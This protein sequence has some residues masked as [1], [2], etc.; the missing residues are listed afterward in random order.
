MHTPE[1]PELPNSD[2]PLDPQ[3]IA[4]ESPQDAPQVDP[5][6]AVLAELIYDRTASNKVAGHRWLRL[7]KPEELTDEKLAALLIA[8]RQAAQPPVLGTIAFIEGSKDTY[9]YDANIMTGQFAR[10]DALIEDK[11]ILRTIAEVTR[12]D[13]QLYP[14][15]TEFSKMMGYPFRFSLDEVEGAAARMQLHDEYQDI[16]VVQASNGAKA[17]YSSQHIKEGY[18][19]SLLEASEVEAREWP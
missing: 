1:H 9:Y 15:P 2:Q 8:I 12:S 18:A 4:E 16:G 13:C 14:R 10:L 5:H 17:F 11:D 6:P 7:N 19:R 3:E